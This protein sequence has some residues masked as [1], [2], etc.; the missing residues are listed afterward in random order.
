MIEK[1]EKPVTPLELNSKINEI[2]VSI[3]NISKEKIGS[4]I[5]V[6]C[7]KDYVPD[8]CL[9]CDGGEYSKTQFP[10][11]WTNYL[12]SEDFETVTVYNDNVT[13]GSGCIDNAGIITNFDSNLTFAI[14]G[15]DFFPLIDFRTGSD[16]ITTQDI[17][18]DESGS[19][20]VYLNLTGGNLKI[21]SSISNETLCAVE[22]NTEYHIFFTYDSVVNM[23]GV[24]IM[25]TNNNVLATTTNKSTL[26][27]SYPFI[28]E[29]GITVKNFLGSIDLTKS[30]YL[31]NNETKI[32]CATQKQSPK[33]LLNTCTYED[34]A[35][36]VETYGQCGKFAVDS[37][38]EKFKTPLI[39]D[40]AIIQQA[41]SDSELGKSYNAGLPNITGEMEITSAKS[42]AYNAYFSGAFALGENLGKQTG[43]GNA[44][45]DYQQYRLAIDASGSNTIYG[46]SDTVQPNAVALRYF[47]VVA[48]GQINESMMDWSA[49]ASGLQSKLNTDLTNFPKPYV[50]EMY[51]NGSSGYVLYSNGFCEQWG[52]AE[53]SAASDTVTLLKPYKNADYNLQISPYHTTLSTDGRPPL[54]YETSKTADS[55]V[56]NLYTSYAGVYWKT[57]GYI[58]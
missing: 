30:Y 10:D 15:N 51:E 55:F 45:S 43:Y 57:S 48:N 1:I 33:T 34:Y 37:E 40:G 7:G 20:P 49:W 47:V 11:L 56:F 54:I 23:Y 46:N 39:K 25:D 27:E 41:L 12:T 18:Y 4:I 21:Y 42:I 16:V 24:T 38:N 32:Y 13:I 29:E 5:S 36:E 19:N 53:R 35:T 26:P 6:A 14:S 22:P 17:I 50:T 58:S 31:I 2:I 28:L 3:D 8:G 44:S 52:K 9:P